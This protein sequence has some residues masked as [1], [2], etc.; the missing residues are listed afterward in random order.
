MLYVVTIKFRSRFVK[1]IR[2]MAVLVLRGAQG[3]AQGPTRFNIKTP[4]IKF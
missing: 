3:F 1:N 2:E 4:L